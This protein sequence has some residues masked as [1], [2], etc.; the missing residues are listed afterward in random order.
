LACDNFLII[1]LLFCSPLFQSACSGGLSVGFSS[2]YGACPRQLYHIF[3][4]PRASGLAVVFWSF[5]GTAPN[6]KLFG[7]SFAAFD[8]PIALYWYTSQDFWEQL[9]VITSILFC[10]GRFYKILVFVIDKCQRAR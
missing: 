10:Q 7:I 2:A 4:P 6:E 9:Q 3:Q 1:L 8:A 5:A